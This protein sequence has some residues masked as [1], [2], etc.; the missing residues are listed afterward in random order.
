M[1]IKNAD[2]ED[3]MAAAIVAVADGK[4]KTPGSRFSAGK[5]R[6]S[7]STNSRTA[8]KEWFPSDNTSAQ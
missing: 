4:E 3:G 8:T 1:K 7:Y 5:V 6:E 2:G